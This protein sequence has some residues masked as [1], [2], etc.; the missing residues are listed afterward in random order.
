MSRARGSRPPPWVVS[1]RAHPPALYIAHARGRWRWPNKPR[2]FVPTRAHVRFIVRHPTDGAIILT[3]PIHF[4]KKINSSRS[5]LKLFKIILTIAPQTWYYSN[6]MV[7]PP[8]GQRNPLDEGSDEPSPAFCKHNYKPEAG[9]FS[10]AW[11]CV[12]CG[13]RWASFY[14]TTRKGPRS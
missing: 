9:L 10:V 4:S 12:H 3:D 13:D 1:V 6:I 14:P 11:I 7:S 2:G 8:L 5:P